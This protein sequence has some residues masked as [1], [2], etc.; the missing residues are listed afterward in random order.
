MSRRSADGARARTPEAVYVVGGMVVIVGGVVGVAVGLERINFDVIVGVM[1]LLFLTMVS[2][3]ALRYV[4]R[5]EKDPKLLPILYGALAAKVV[6]TLVRY[7]FITVIYNDNGDAGVYSG[8]GAILMQ[9]YRQGIFAVE[10]PGLSARGAETA[11]IAMVVGFIYLITGVSRYAA[12]FV[13]SWM[14]FT[15]QVLMYRAFKRGVPEGDHRR[16]AVLVLFL[17]SMLFWPSS[18]GKE[19]LMVF[20]IGFVSYGAAQLLG[21]RVKIS[22]IVTFSLG[23]AGLLFIRPHMALIAITALGFAAAVSTVVGFSGEVDKKAKS[24]AF[25]VRMVALVVLIG[26]GLGATTQVS[27]V[28]GDGT[29]G[30]AGITGV[31]ARTQAQTAEGGSKFN[32]VAVTNPAQFPAATV[33]VLF[34]PFPW[35]AR[36]L[37]GVIA[38]GEGFLLL[39]LMVI[40][41]RRL[42]SWARMLGKR[43]YLVF[44]LAYA[45]TFIVAF[46]YIGNFGILARQRTQ[47]LPLALTPLGM[48]LA[49]RRRSGLFGGKADEVPEHAPVVPVG[50]PV[51]PPDIAPSPPGARPAP[52]LTPRLQ[53]GS[54]QSEVGRLP[55]GDGQR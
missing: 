45:A 25:A 44:C 41:R 31:L 33:T 1:T 22:G 46:S 19:A 16:Y 29:E 37:N 21:A 35:E 13:F 40:G 23:A 32:A 10:V 51:L 49:A 4:S 39:T 36:N 26:G 12:S 14:C 47:M 9:S 53:S 28:L 15:G 8:A 38:S 27:K 34:R 50:A 2:I 17:P 24:K 48:P 6:G 18:I 5:V 30:T 42:L 3:P 54:V 11:R 55:R 7:F 43:P 20:C 52:V